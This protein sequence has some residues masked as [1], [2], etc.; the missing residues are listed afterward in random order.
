MPHWRNPTLCKDSDMSKPYKQQHHWL[1]SSEKELLIETETLKTYG[2][3]AFSRAGPTL[4]NKLPLSIRTRTHCKNLNLPL[5]LN[6]LKKPVMY[7]S[8]S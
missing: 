1:R 6:F 3:R 5:R 4:L 8:Y 7:M 2:D